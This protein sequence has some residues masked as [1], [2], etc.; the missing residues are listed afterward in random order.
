MSIT[1]GDLAGRILK[2][3][4]INTRFTEAEPEQ[5]LDVVNYAQDWFLAQNAQGRRLGWVVAGGNPNLDAESGIP[6]WSIL[7]STYSI[8]IMIA[9]Y[10][11]KA[12]SPAIQAV[13]A[14]GMQVIVSNTVANETVQYPTRMPMGQGNRTTY[15]NRW[16]RQQDRITTGGDFLQDEGE[17]IITSGDGS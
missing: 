14:D 16:F 6:D 2:I 11:D 4:G 3:I 17:D 9:P 5:V 1:K 12:L 10:F 15:T 7:G 8:A 13:A